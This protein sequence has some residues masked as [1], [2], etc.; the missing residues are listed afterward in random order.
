MILRLVLV[1][2]T[3]SGDLAT[4]FS[5]NREVKVCREPMKRGYSTSF[6]AESEFVFSFKVLVEL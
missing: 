5:T 2:S 3:I 1:F 6:D 4:E